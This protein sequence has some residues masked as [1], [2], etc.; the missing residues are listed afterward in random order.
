MMLK[1]DFGQLCEAFELCSLTNH[2]FID[3]EKNELIS[4]N[5]EIDDEPEKKLEEINEEKF[6]I[7][8]ERTS[9]EDYLIMESF[10]YKIA[11]KDF[12]L[13]DKFYNA[14]HKNKPFRRFKE[15]LDEYP[16]F[17]DRWFKFKE[18]QIK[19]E[20]IDWLFENEIILEDQKLIPD[21]DIKELDNS[22]IEK[23]PEGLKD[24]AP[25]TCMNCENE[26]KIIAKFF[27]VNCD[28]ENRMINYEIKRIMREKY[29]IND[30][31]VMSTGKGTILTYAK[32]LKC[33]GEDIFW[34]Y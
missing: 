24:F 30:Y 21:L 14:I 10:I 19:N 11:E 7:I 3:L 13:S 26:E 20:V 34:D 29:N 33:G 16:E 12:R 18:K 5:E 6:L 15:M 22:E 17:K 2:Y 31:G 9:D 32:C 27:R 28:I 8:P 25:M 4:I 1:I 23:I